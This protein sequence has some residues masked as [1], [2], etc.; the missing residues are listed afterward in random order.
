MKGGL[1]K[2]RYTTSMPLDLVFT[3]KLGQVVRPVHVS[4]RRSGGGA[5]DE[6]LDWRAKWRG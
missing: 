1:L 2:K 3:Y 4:R 5:V 6:T